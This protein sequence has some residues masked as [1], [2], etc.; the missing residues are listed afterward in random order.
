MKIQ[1]LLH[2]TPFLGEN[3]QYHYFYKI[4]NLLNGR[5]YYGI[6]STKNLDDGYKGSGIHIK[7][8][9]QKYKTNNFEK[10]IL[11]FFQTRLQLLQYESE[12]VTE[13]IIYDR[14]SYNATL[15]GR[16]SIKMYIADNRKQIIELETG[17]IIDSIQTLRKLVKR[18][19]LDSPQLNYFVSK[20]GYHYA[21]YDDSLNDSNSRQILIEQIKVNIKNRYEQGCQ[22]RSKGKQHA[23]IDLQTFQIFN[24]RQQL[25][26]SFHIDSK[27][28]ATGQ[29]FDNG[30]W[31]NNGHYFIVYD[32]TKSIDYYK[33]LIDQVYQYENRKRNHYQAK[34]VM[35]VETG[36]IFESCREAS[37]AMG[38]SKNSIVTTVNGYQKTAGGYHWQLM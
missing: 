21:L 20:V 35:C 18:P 3:Q 24:S 5:Y 27:I 12:I 31:K 1:Y 19:K 4:V 15:G 7:K 25:Y 32:L 16:N 10:H 37:K 29:R 36:E 2:D 26:E 38:L 28:K 17:K 34:R 22:N 23:W 14:K 13:Q 6:H 9:I 30:V 11:K 33:Q 8:A